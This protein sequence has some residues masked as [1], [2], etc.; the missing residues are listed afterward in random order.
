MVETSCKRD[1][2]KFKKRKNF[3]KE[4]RE[5]EKKYQEYLKK[6]RSKMG[7]KP[8]G[9]PSHYKRGEKDAN[10]SR[11]RD[12]ARKSIHKNKKGYS[13][14]GDAKT[15]KPNSSTWVKGYT[16]ERDGKTIRVPP[17]KRF[18]YSVDH[19]KGTTTDFEKAPRKT[20]GKGKKKKVKTYVPKKKSSSTKKK[21][22][23]TKKSTSS[24]SKKS[25]KG[26]SGRTS[27]K[28]FRF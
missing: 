13:Y 25:K 2:R 6:E 8:Q 11:K 14:T 18:Y 24:K 9:K 10:I 20:R 23:T 5:E 3:E 21:T 4:Q 17:H 16:M 12:I 15:V 7:T 22:S 26:K 1:C 19:P 28:G 27:Y